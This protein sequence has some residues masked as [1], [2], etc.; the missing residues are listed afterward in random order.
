MRTTV[1]LD[2][3]SEQL[4]RQAMQQT[5]DSFKV[6]LN[7]AIRRGLADTLPKTAEQR[8]Q[9][10]AKNMGLKPGIRLR[11]VKQLERRL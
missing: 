2:H 5:G 7:R 10:K 1:T 4:L 11:Q 3:D 8:F 6:T 9:V